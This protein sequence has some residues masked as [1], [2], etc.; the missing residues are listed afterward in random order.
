MGS[1][2][3]GIGTAIGAVVG[4]IGGLLAG[5]FSKKK[6]KVTDDLMKVFP[7]LVDEAGN[8]NKEL[9]KH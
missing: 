4:T 9:A 3:P 5:I 1:I 2:I 8:L 7:G 6:N